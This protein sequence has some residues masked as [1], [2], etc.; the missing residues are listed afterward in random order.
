MTRQ[1]CDLNGAWIKR[2]DSAVAPGAAEEAGTGARGLDSS[3]YLRSRIESVTRGLCV[4]WLVLR[5]L[6]Q[7][8]SPARK[9]LRG[10]LGA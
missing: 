5:F 3:Q 4:F 6:L 10:P 1:H 7:A 9:L 2:V 8:D